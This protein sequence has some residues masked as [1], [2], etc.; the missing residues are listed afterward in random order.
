MDAIINL[1]F[2]ITLIDSV[3]EE[4]IINNLD[5]LEDL[6]E[7]IMDDCDEDDDFDYNDDD[8]MVLADFITNGNWIIDEYS[9][10]GEDFTENYINYIF[11]F[12]A[13]GNVSANNGQQL[14]SGTW[15]IDASNPASSRFILN[16]E[17][18]PPFNAL[19]QNWLIEE[20]EVGLLALRVGSEP[21][22]DLR[23]LVFE[24]P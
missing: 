20:S 10:M 8:D 6:I 16:F 9:E 24:K 3:D 2:P 22:G 15:S 13:N 7:D 23:I 12:E 14:V 19:N 17:A 18:I 4:V 21:T 5:D 11:N 1:T